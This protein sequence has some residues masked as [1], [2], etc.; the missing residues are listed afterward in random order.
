MSCH[1]CSFKVVWRCPR[2]DT[3]FCN[4]CKQNYFPQTKEG[5]IN[6]DGSCNCS[7]C[8]IHDGDT[9]ETEKT[10]LKAENIR[11]IFLQNGKQIHINGKQNKQTEYDTNRHF[12]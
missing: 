9:V 7:K 1:G 3:I 10:R 12:C 2:C 11:R 8:F 5:C 6:C 4:K